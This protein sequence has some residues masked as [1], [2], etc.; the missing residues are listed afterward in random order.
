MT[1]K[2]LDNQWY[3][4]VINIGNTWEQYSI[5]VWEKHINDADA[6]LQRIFNE[7]MAF[8]PEEVTVYNFT[9]NKSPSYLTNIKVYTSTI[10][11][12]KQSNDLLSYFTPNADQIIILDNADSILK[13]PYI[14]KQR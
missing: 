8:Y 14:G 2:L 10:E 5:N 1:N 9:V 3:G 7:T 4:I 13:I 12:E 6:K 11:E